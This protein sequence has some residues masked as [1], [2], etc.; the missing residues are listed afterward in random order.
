[1]LESVAEALPALE[2]VAHEQANATH[3][4]LV[5]MGA[6]EDVDALRE[7]FRDLR[8][9]GGEWRLDVVHGAAVVSLVGLRLGAAEAARAERALEQAGIA[10]VALRVTP[11][12]IVL[13][14]DTRQAEAAVRALHAQ[15]LE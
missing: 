15:F 8:G 11:S 2:L 12:A 14:V 1:I 9:P 10:L 5:W 6:P 3:G 13:R 7:R 4:A